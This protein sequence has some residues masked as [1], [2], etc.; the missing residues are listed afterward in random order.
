[1]P[2]SFAIQTSLDERG[3][4]IHGFVAP[5]LR[6]GLT[7]AASAGGGAWWRHLSAAAAPTPAAAG[8]GSSRPLAAGGWQRCRVDPA[9]KVEEA[10]ICIS[11]H[12][13]RLSEEISR[14]H[15]IC[16]E[17]GERKLSGPAVAR[18]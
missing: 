9:A 8:G 4:L 3:S 12:E 2:C 1:M 15:S 10:T 11:D 14:R 16:V 7:I 13:V 6:Q 5:P 17:G 18:A